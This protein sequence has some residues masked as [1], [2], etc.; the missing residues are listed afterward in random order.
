MIPYTTP[1]FRFRAKEDS[2]IDFT[3]AQKI[4]FSIEQ[5]DTILSKIVSNAQEKVVEV[6]LSQEESGRFIKGKAKVQLNVKFSNSN[7]TASYVRE[8]YISEQLLE[9]VIS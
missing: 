2:G 9:E 7:R 6:A 1:T 4:M 8:I 5:G 3:Q